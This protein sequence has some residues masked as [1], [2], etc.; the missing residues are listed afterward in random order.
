LKVDTGMSRLG[1]PLSE[2]GAV[3]DELGP[4]ELVGV[5][6]H[7]ASA[8]DNP[9]ATERQIDR[10]QEAVAAIC[11]RGHTPRLLHA[12]NSAGALLRPRSRCSLVRAGLALYGVPPRVDVDVGLRPVM[13][14]RSEV[15]G[16]RELMPGDAIGYGGTHR[17]KRSMRVA[18]LPIGYGDGLLRAASD[19]AAVLIGGALCPVVGRVSMDLTTVNVD[20]VAGCRVGDE[21]V[22]IGTSGERTLTAADLA[23][24]CGTIPYE[25]L[26]TLAPRVPRIYQS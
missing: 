5:M 11:T 25:V 12:A 16:L 22:V 2:L 18:T 1:V 20:A 8:E 19:R 10:F 3:L 7:L 23:Q 21:A 14:L 24:A 9:D 26:T 17:V 13:R 6:T 15:M 4:L